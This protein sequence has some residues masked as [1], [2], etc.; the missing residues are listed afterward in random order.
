MVDDDIWTISELRKTCDLGL[1]IRE[2][3]SK[4]LLVFFGVLSSAFFGSGCSF[5]L[6]PLDLELK[7]DWKPTENEAKCRTMMFVPEL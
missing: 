1:D 5:P 3:D 4:R 2:V 7:L 6:L